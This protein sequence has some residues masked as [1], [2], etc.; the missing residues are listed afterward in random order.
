M[1]FACSGS[2]LRTR[3][4]LILSKGTPQVIKPFGT[5][6]PA[7]QTETRKTIVIILDL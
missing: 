3:C 7:A 5:I 1:D 2:S 6:S 4:W